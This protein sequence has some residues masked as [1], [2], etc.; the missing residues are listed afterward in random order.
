M[1]CALGLFNWL[2]G[3]SHSVWKER[4]G[5]VSSKDFDNDHIRTGSK[6]N[7]QVSQKPIKRRIKCRKVINQKVR[8]IVHIAD[9]RGKFE[10]LTASTAEAIL[11]LP[12]TENGRLLSLSSWCFAYSVWFSVRILFILWSKSTARSKNL[13]WKGGDAIQLNRGIN[14]TKKLRQ[15]IKMILWPFANARTPSRRNES[16]IK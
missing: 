6:E 12:E 7:V 5:N 15:L 9:N 10:E 8:F 16:E 2:Q 14:L 13:S 1:A 4:K 3:A 11:W